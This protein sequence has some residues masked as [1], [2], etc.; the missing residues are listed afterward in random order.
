MFVRVKKSPHSEK[1]AVQIVESFRVGGKVRQRIVRHVGMAKDEEELKK[2]I[3]LA[4]YIRARMESEERPGLFSAEEM[5]RYAIEG[6]KEKGEKELRVDLRKLREKKR[7]VVGIHEAYGRIYKELGFDRVIGN[8]A[9]RRAGVRNLFHIVMGRLSSGVSKMRTVKEMGE[10]FGVELS[11]PSVY[12]MMDLLDEGVKRRI[13][14]RAYDAACGLLGGRIKVIFYDCTTIYF[15]SF[16]EDEIRRK[17]YSKDMKFNETQVL[18]G[19]MVTERGLPV[20]YEVYEGSRYEGNTVRDAIEKIRRR[21]KVEEV[22]FVGDSGILNKKNIEMIEKLGGKYILGA[23]I[24]GMSKE[25][26]EEIGKR[27]S[28]KEVVS[29]DGERLWIK[30]IELGEGKRL[31]VTFSEARARKDAEDRQEAIQRLMKKIDNGGLR[32]EDLVRNYGYKRFIKVEGECE[33]KIDEKKIEEDKKWDGLHGVITNHEGMKAE[34]VI[35]QYGG[36]WQVEETFRIT[37]HDLKVRPIYHWTPRRIRAHIAICFMA[38]C[39]ARHLEYRLAV[40][41][42]AMSVERIRRALNSVQVS[43]LE[44]IDTKALYGIPSL[45]REDAKII[46]DTLGLKLSDVPYEIKRKESN[47]ELSSPYARV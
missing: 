12:R 36:L 4:E 44:H 35:A 25:V 30:E 28:Y 15:E 33:V 1:K 24:K 31:I 43:I 37:K 11:L 41:K 29:R 27:E 22:I 9:R 10:G 8:P 39:C 6:R 18:L 2:L 32:P 14:D 38:L 17:G 20:G 42:K 46:Y 5:A 45:I 34:E 47:K 3:E 26:K 16:K 13:E 40:Q 19:V 23:R 7:V 21:Y